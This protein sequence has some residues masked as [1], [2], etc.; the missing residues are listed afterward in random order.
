MI[1]SWDW[2]KEYLNLD[3]SVDEVALR[4]AMAGLNHESTNQ[5]GDDF[6]I[7]IEITSN[8]PDCLGH[9]GIARE[10]AVLWEQVCKIPDP[11]PTNGSTRAK[12]LVKVSI[13]CPDL[14]PRYTARVVQGAKVSAQPDLDAVAIGHDR[15][16]RRQQRR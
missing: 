8:R 15:N 12:D 5:V 7:D 16:C 14:C 13:E 1:V 9:L 6:A 4:L 3:M 11:Q 10:I 2:L